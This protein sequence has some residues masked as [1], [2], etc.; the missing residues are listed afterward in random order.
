MITVRTVETEVDIDTY[1]DVRN[2]VHS[3]TPIPRDA[4]LHAPVLVPFRVHRRPAWRTA[5]LGG[6]AAT[7]GESA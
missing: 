2:R 6:V 1:I 7:R 5:V 3:R 4:V